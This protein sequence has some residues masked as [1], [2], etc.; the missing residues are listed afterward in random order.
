MNFFGALFV[1]LLLAAVLVG[2]VVF[3]VKSSIWLLAIALV[4][5][6][7]AFAKYG[8]LTH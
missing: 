6:A 5:F 8:C 2:A 7:I 1:W 4:L 3:A